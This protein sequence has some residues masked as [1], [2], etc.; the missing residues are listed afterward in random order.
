MPGPLTRIARGV[1]DL[2]FADRDAPAPAAHLPSGIRLRRYM[3]AAAA[4]ALPCLAVAA[5]FLGSRV[6]LVAAVSFAAAWPVEQVVARLRGRRSRGGALTVALLLALVLPVSLPL[7]LVALTAAFGTFFGK[8]VFGGTGHSVFNPVLIGKAFVTVSF[9]TLTTGPSFTGLSMSAIRQVGSMHLAAAEAGG[10]VILAA[11]VVLLFWRAVDW[12]VPATTIAVGLAAVFVLGRL[13][14]GDA[15]TLYRFLLGGGF[16]FGALVLA[17]DP[18][19]APGTRGARYFYGLL[20]GALAA[21]IATFTENADYAMYAILLGN[22]A[23]PTMDATAL[24]ETGG[25]GQP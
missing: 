9:P 7:W 17:G 10:A 13:G 16:L 11:G 2:A 20:I 15:P 19:T 23:A 22:V 5:F 3:V 14:L 18:G 12:R 8:E 25:E 4:C 6:L 21:L 1:G 24:G